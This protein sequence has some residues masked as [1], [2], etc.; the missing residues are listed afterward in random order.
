MTLITR[1][2]KRGQIGRFNKGRGRTHSRLLIFQTQRRES[3]LGFTITGAGNG[4]LEDH[5]KKSHAVS[6]G[7]DLRPWNQPWDILSWLL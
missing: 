1:P 2:G 7:G 4:R 5:F 6:G 3:W